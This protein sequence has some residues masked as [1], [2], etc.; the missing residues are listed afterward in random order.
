MLLLDEPAAGMNDSESAA[1]R[2]LLLEIRER[3]N[4]TM[5]VIEHD[6]PF[7]MGLAGRL[8]VLDEGVTIAQGTAA[9]IRG[10]PAVIEAYLGQDEE[11]ER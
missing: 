7:V 2:A 11:R 1:L 6:M 10:N 9:E 5:L 8:L 3:F 4:L